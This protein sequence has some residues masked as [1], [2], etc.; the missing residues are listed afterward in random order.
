[1]DSLEKSEDFALREGMA[2]FRYHVS[3]RRTHDG[4]AK[5]EEGNSGDDGDR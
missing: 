5:R 2:R 3:E 4:I 1:M